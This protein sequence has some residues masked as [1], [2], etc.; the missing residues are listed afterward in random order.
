M[1]T[2]KIQIKFQNGVTSTIDENVHKLIIELE[3]KIKAQREL[4]RF[5]NLTK[6][7]N[8]YGE[9]FLNFYSYLLS[10][11]KSSNA[12]LFQDLFVLFILK[13]KRGGTFLE[14]GATDGVQLSNSF[15][16]ENKFGWRGVL[17][18]PSPQWH[19]KLNENRPTSNIITECIY[20]ESE[21]NLDFFVSDS[22]ALSTLEQFRNSDISS[23]PL[24]TEARNSKGYRYQ[25]STISLNDVFVKYFQSTPIDYMSVDTEGSELLILEN[26]DF[27]KFAPK[28]VTV[29][30][31][32]T[33]MQDKLDDLFKKNN[34]VRVF[35]EHTQFDAWYILKD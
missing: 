3:Q 18:E 15:L 19:K 5:F 29:E 6:A 4:P 34:Y 31:N 30:H 16:L 22:G 26:F 25:V 7:M 35:K 17:A 13:E 10:N 8:Q 12:Q 11:N 28:I 1:K 32:F 14:F 9:D 2:K 20:S 33:D 21:K 23:M 27:K 24:N